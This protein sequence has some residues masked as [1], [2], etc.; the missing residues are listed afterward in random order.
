MDTASRPGALWH[1][2]ALLLI[3]LA[4]D[5]TFETAAFLAGSTVAEA[6]VLSATGARHR[7]PHGPCPAVDL[8]LVSGERRVAAVASCR[9]RPAYAA[10]ERLAV[11]YRPAD[12]S[13]VVPDTVPDL[14]GRAIACW[15]FAAG[16]CL[17]AGELRARW[18]GARVRG[19]RRP[20]PG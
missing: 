2:A 15:I 16:F 19:P 1:A 7:L 11:R 6:T 8:A 12:A 18:S 9:A 3:G 10:G 20:Q 13:V 14:W 17:C 5:Q 4:L